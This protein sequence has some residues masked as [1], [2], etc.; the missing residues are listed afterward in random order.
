MYS[1]R[2][3]HPTAEARERARLLVIKSS[4]KEEYANKSDERINGRRRRH[5]YDRTIVTNNKSCLFLWR[6][7]NMKIG[8][9]SG[10]L[11]EGKH[12]LIERYGGGNMMI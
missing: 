7:K 12:R 2:C 1:K 6:I 5:H 10:W 4:G 9:A 11:S 8:M 3:L